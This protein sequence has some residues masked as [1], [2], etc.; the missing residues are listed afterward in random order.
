MVGIA[1]GMPFEL[2]QFGLF[3]VS[4]HIDATTDSNNEGRPLVTVTSKDSFGRMFFV[5]H[6]FLPSEQSW[7]YKWLFQT[8]FPV[9]IGKDVLNKLSI[10]VTDGAAQE[11]TQ[12]EE[13]AKVFSP[14]VYRIR[15]SWHI[16]NRGWH[17][18]VKVSLGGHSRRKRPLHLNGKP[19]KALPLLTQ[20][21]KTART[22]YRWIFSWAQLSYCESEE[23]MKFVQSNKVKDLFGSKF[24]ESVVLF[25]RE[26]VFPGEHRFCYYKRHGLFHL[27]THTNCGHKGTNNSMKNCSSPV[28]AQKQLDQA[29]K[30]L[31]FNADIKALNTQ[32]IVCHKTNSRKLWSDSPT[33]GHVTDVCKSMLQTE[34]S[35]AT[36]WI[37]NQVSK[38]RWLLIHHL[39]KE[40]SN[41]E[42]WSDE[43]K[44]SDDNK[45]IDVN[46]IS[47]PNGDDE[48]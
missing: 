18:R 2:E 45:T 15:C 48:K 6:A 41:L 42:Y 23:D 31:N 36:Y 4:M 25:V 39:E 3:H 30:T 7:A 27:E 34:W 46:V 26:N 9:L 22:I 20:S 1:Y 28:M 8:V 13:A 24:V 44:L 37:P 35:Q 47:S 43:G 21:N 38:F 40:R 32:I 14:N 11:I 19:R 29:I 16:I 33:S 12:L 10:V 17:K 5:L